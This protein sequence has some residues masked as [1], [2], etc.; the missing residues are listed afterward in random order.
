MGSSIDRFGRLILALEKG[1][2][3]EGS[4]HYLGLV[5][6]AEFPEEV[7][8]VRQTVPPN[9]DPN[10][11]RGGQRLWFFDTTNHLPVLTIAKD[12]TGR[13]VEY[14]CNDRIW[15]RFQLNDD[16]FSPKHLWPGAK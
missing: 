8:G 10:L 6:R 5:K 4:A 2:T 9:T 13:E 16:D 12:E 14:Y 1:D 7:A 15:L 11:P 3:R